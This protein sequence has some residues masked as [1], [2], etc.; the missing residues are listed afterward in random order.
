ML[1]SKMPILFNLDQHLLHQ[2]GL[3]GLGEILGWVL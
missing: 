1:I 3:D 2:E